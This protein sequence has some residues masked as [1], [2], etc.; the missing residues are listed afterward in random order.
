MVRRVFG[1]GVDELVLQT[2]D[3]RFLVVPPLK[4]FLEEL[5]AGRLTAMDKKVV[6]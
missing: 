2:E 4:D 6:R 3:V 5:F 1:V